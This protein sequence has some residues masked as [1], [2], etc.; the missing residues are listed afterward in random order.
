MWRAH[1]HHARALSPTR[2]SAVLVA[3]ASTMK[4]TMGMSGTCKQPSLGTIPMPI[5]TRSSCGNQVKSTA[6]SQPSYGFGTATRDGM[7]NRF[8]SNAHTSKEAPKGTPGPGAY[9]HA[10]STGKQPNSMVRQVPAYKVGTENRFSQ[11]ERDHKRTGAVPGPGA[12]L[13]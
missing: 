3:M 13:I 1:H 4:S 12:Y 10:V 9:K 5:G 6:S 7:K 11:Q 2:R 8:I